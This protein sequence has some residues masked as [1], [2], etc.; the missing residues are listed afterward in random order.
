MQWNVRRAGTGYGA[1]SAVFLHQ[2]VSILARLPRLLPCCAHDAHTRTPSAS[3]AA[4]IF[5]AYQRQSQVLSYLVCIRTRD[6]LLVRGP[7]V[8]L[9]SVHGLDHELGKV[10]VRVGTASAASG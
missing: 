5:Y 3:G 9:N 8:L 10:R 7:S 1:H 6:L 4:R 2:A